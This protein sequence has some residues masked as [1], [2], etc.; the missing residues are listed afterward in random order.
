MKTHKLV[1]VIKMLQLS[2]EDKSLQ[3]VH[4]KQQSIDMLLDKTYF[5]SR[6]VLGSL[7]YISYAQWKV[8][9]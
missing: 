3:K 5:M 1:N 4:V 8:I 6:I 9:K 2:L 7:F